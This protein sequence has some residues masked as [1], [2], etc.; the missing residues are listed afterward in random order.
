MHRYSRKHL[1]PEDAMRNL[2]AIDLEE[3]SKLTKGIALIAVIDERRDYLAAGCSCMRNYYMG[4]LHMSEDKALQRIQVAK[5]ALRFPDV[6]ECLAD[7][8]PS[9][10]T[11]SVLAPHLAPLTA[12]ALLEAAAFRSRPEIVRILAVRSC[13]ASGAPAEQWNAQKSQPMVQTVV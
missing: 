8:R 2:D 3:K 1:S 4:R 9:V 7:G 10:T 12:S 13:A 11:A 6:F 5:A